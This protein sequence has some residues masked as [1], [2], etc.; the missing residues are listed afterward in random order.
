M[1]L[2]RSL[3]SLAMTGGDRGKKNDRER[4][5][6]GEITVGSRQTQINLDRLNR[7]NRHGLVF[8]ISYWYFMVVLFLFELLNLFFDLFEFRVEL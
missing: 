2:P 1:G 4:G 3:R 5:G 8:V 6:Q 7:L